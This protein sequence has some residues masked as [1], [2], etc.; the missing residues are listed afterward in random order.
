MQTQRPEFDQ[1][2]QLL[3]QDEH[4]TLQR[5]EALVHQ[6]QL[7]V[8]DPTAL[9]NSVA[10]VVCDALRD[11]QQKQHWELET[12][13]SPLV[14]GSIRRELRNSQD[15]MVEAFYPILGRLVSS[16]VA[17]R[18]KQF[19]EALDERIGSRL[20]GTRLLLRVKSL[21]TGVPYKA[22]LLRDACKFTILEVSLIQR[23]SGIL[24]DHWRSPDEE[25]RDTDDSNDRLFSGFIAAIN[26]FAN[27]ALRSDDTTLRSFET[28]DS[29]IY[30]RTSSAHILAV[31]TRG[32]VDANLERILDRT[33]LEIV[34]SELVRGREDDAE[35]PSK[36]R[37]GRRL[38]E[39]A[40]QLIDAVADHKRTPVL[41]IVALVTLA[42]V[43]G[44]FGIWH[45]TA[46]SPE[47]AARQQ[48]R[49][50]VD[51]Q[52][53]LAGFPIRIEVSGETLLVSGLVPSE[54]AK[55][56]LQDAVAAASPAFDLNWELTSIGDGPVLEEI[57]EIRDIIAQLATQESLRALDQRLGAELREIDGRLAS[58]RRDA[59]RLASQ[60]SVDAL[61]QRS[62]AIA[63]DV[64]TLR[65]RLSSEVARLDQET[66]RFALTRDLNRL[67]DELNKLVGNVNHPDVRLFSWVQRN[68]IFFSENA[69]IREPRFAGLQ[70]DELAQLMKESKMG[71]RI[72]G[73]TDPSGTDQRNKTIAAARAIKV[74]EALIA[75]GIDE[76]RLKTVGRQQGP[77]LSA[78][79]GPTSSNRRVEF[80][81]LHRSEPARTTG[82]PIRESEID[83]RR[84]ETDGR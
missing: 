74:E 26:E 72:V 83:L 23:K 2:K 82:E 16:Y 84:I 46:L 80:E 20:S 5:L 70:L 77:L 22:L 69:D 35:R 79:V 55:R 14:V 27:D 68:A 61:R 64:D 10:E 45:Y 49:E 39:A 43:G 31:R 11:A 3:L 15:Q 21:W 41:G 65:S 48:V 37:V 8:G 57:A 54:D 36:S 30:L 42:V 24:I 38:P 56:D 63:Q 25:M 13:V 40:E 18:F 7:R 28:P 75:R 71:L 6:H 34:E 66:N 76:D 53:Q 58:L 4:H 19:V 51:Q 17:S 47:E 81:L 12:T 44:G 62:S 78:D 33:L 32:R 52:S 73:Y 59:A 60:A 67:S 1:L 50:I 29:R 9:R